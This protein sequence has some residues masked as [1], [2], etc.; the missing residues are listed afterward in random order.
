MSIFAKESFIFEYY[1]TSC[2]SFLSVRLRLQVSL[3]HSNSTPVVHYYLWKLKALESLIF[4]VRLGAVVSVLFVIGK[5]GSTALGK[6]S[7][8]LKEMGFEGVKKKQQRVNYFDSVCLLRYVSYLL[9]H[10]V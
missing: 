1:L 9:L 4:N 10:S 6:L 8:F 3:S 7:Y 2:R 5:V